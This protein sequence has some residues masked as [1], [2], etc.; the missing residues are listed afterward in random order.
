MNS[1]T[2]ENIL[3]FLKKKEGR[4]LPEKWKNSEMKYT[5]S[6]RYQLENYPDGTQYVYDSYLD[7]AD[8]NITKLP[9]DL[10][11]RYG[12]DLENCM[13][14]I[15]LPTKLYVGGNLYLNN[16]KINKL[17]DE[18]HVEDYLNLENCKQLTELPDNLHVGGNLILI[19]CKQLTELPNNLY[20]GRDLV[21][22]GTPL[23]EKYTNAKIRKIIKSTGGQIIGKIYR[24]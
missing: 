16:T 21:L 4:K 20:I 8:S 9:K 5:L 15:E 18:L 19:N 22:E 13:Q 1:K 12:L 6:L 17:P 3:K 2:I 24:Q 11:V 7:L 10:Y 14:L 23:L